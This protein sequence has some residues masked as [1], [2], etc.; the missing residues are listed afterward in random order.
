MKDQSGLTLI[1]IMI[2]LLIASVALSG[3]LYMISSAS[4]LASQSKANKEASQ[5]AASEMERI[6]NMDFDA[7]GFPDA[8]ENEPLG[9]LPRTT[10]KTTEITTYYI[11][12]EIQWVN[13]PDTASETRDYKRVRI[14]V[15]WQKPSRG[16]YSLVSFISQAA[17][18]AP[19]RVV[20]PPP[21]EIVIP[22]TPQP[23]SLVKGTGVPITVR[24]NEP[25]MLFSAIEVRIGNNL[26]GDKLLV[27]PPSSYKE[28]TYLWDTTQFEDGRYE[29]SAYAYEA[30]GGTSYRSWYYIVDNSPPTD[31]PVLRLLSAGIN[32]VEL[33]WTTIK[34]GYET[35]PTYEFRFRDLYRGTTQTATA[36]LTG[37]DTELSEVTR[38]FAVSPWGLH[39]VTVRGL[40]YGSYGPWSN[41]IRAATRL[42]LNI[43][44]TEQKNEGIADLY[45]TQKPANVTLIRFE[46]VRRRNNTE[47]I[48]A[49]ITNPDVY[50]YRDTFKKQDRSEYS[51]KVRAFFTYE[52]SSYMIDSEWVKP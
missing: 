49:T 35:V 11:R 52:G 8:T 18:R 2:A 37:A 6:R 25:S 42:Q 32:S 21:P 13:D 45:W 47:T 51:Y 36:T 44:Y 27:Q 29:I 28:F 46:V 50:T 23:G 4:L 22:P 26:A 39:A 15:T 19:G 17:R 34:D 48:I 43:K 33:S 24:V 14:V 10:T 1:E 38:S 31:S 7:I 12:Y 9:I 3:I 41:E 16:S 20:V 5:I 30:R 40:S